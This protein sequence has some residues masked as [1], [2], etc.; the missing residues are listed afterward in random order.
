[1]RPQPPHRHLDSL[2]EM[3]SGSLLMPRRST[4]LGRLEREKGGA[5]FLEKPGAQLRHSQRP[6]HRSSTAKK[7]N[8]RE[9]QIQPA[10]SGDLPRA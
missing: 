6:C 3:D 2:T 5:L 4:S 10:R 9:P 8:A 7:R 1:M